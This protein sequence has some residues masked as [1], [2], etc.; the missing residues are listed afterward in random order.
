[1][2]MNGLRSAMVGSSVTNMTSNPMPTMAIGTNTLHPPTYR[3]ARGAA[4][5]CVMTSNEIRLLLGG[6]PAED[7][8]GGGWL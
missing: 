3:K 4:T 7:D 5:R 1:M 6:G 2:F 8:N